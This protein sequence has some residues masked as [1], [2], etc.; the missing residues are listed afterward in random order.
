LITGASTSQAATWIWDQNQNRI[1]DRI[2]SVNT[3]GL[4]AA[5][6]HHDLA[7]KPIIHVFPG[8]T[9]TYGVYVG[10]DHHPTDAD[11][12]ALTAAGATLTWRPRYIDYLRA[13]ASFAQIQTLAS[14]GG[15]TRVEAWQVM[16]PFN[17]NATRTLRARDAEGGVG[18][19]MFPSVWKNLGYTGK[20]VVVGII[21]TGVNDAAFGPYPGHESLRGKWVGGGDFSNPDASLNTPP[22][23]SANPQNSADPLG[24]YHAT[25]V[26]GTSIGSGGPQGLLNGAAPGRYAGMAPDARLVDCKALSDAGVG[27]GAAEALEWCIAHRSTVWNANEPG[28]TYRG[29]QV[30]NMSLGG[31]SASDGTDADCAAVNAAVK[32]GIAVCVA[33][34]NDGNTA[35][36]P[37]PAAA[38]QDIAVGAFQDA[39]SLQHS[40]DIVADYSN[41][42]PRMTDGDADHYDEMKPSVMGS[43]SDIVSALGDPSSNG[44]LYHNINGTSMATPCITGICALIL[45]ANPNLTPAQLRDVLQN[46]AEH[47]TDHGKQAPSAAD[48]FHLDPNYHPSWGWGETDAY[49]AVKEALNNATTQVVAEGTSSV[50]NMGGHLQIGIRWVTQREI[51]VTRFVVHRAP[52]LGGFPGD[53]TLASPDVTP[54]GHEAIERVSNRTLYNWTDSDLSL[55]VGDT[56][57]YQVRWTDTHGFEHVEPAFAVKTDVPPVRARVQ[58]VLTHTALDNDVFARFGSGTSYLTPAYL[59]ATGGTSS[60][61]SSRVVFPVGFG[62]MTRYFFHAD[63]TDRDVVAPF[64]PPSNANPWFLAV[65]EKGYV[66]TEGF[67]DSFSVTTYDDQGQP[68]GTQ[69]ALN[70]STPTAEGQTTVFWIPADPATQLNHT[71]VL[72]P[73]GHKSGYQG[74]DLTFQVHAT[75]A[76]AQAI[77]Y[78]ASGL[79]SGAT[80]DPGTRTFD[81]TP[82]FSQSGDFTVTFKATDTM[83]A[84]DAEDVVLSIATR[85]PGS[86]T[87]PVLAPIGDRTTQAGVALSFH[88]TATDR[89]G[90]PLTYS[91]TPLPSG[92]T[93]DAPTATFSWTPGAGDVGVYSVTFKVEDS[94]SASDSQPVTIT[95]TSGGTSFPTSCNPE[96]TTFTGTIGADVQGTMN[97]F[98]LHPFSV[99]PGTIEIQGALSWTGGPAIDLD[100]YLLDPSGNVASSGATATSDPEHALYVNPDPGTYQWKVVSFDNP[101]PN[102]AYTVTSMLCMSTL[103]G[104]GGG[105]NAELAL[106]PNAPNP[107]AKSSVIRFALAR[108]GEVKLRIYDL[109]GRLIRTL[110]NG[111]MEAGWHQRVWDGR[112]DG[113]ERAV[114]GV[115][116]SRLDAPQG[117]R[118]SKMVMIK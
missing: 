115:Y 75:D 48:P 62:P 89:E 1:D 46:T 55:V 66:N 93:F 3:E 67:V 110:V 84:F 86:N 23:S 65:L 77:T 63:L 38:D 50:S 92:A 28:V 112:S 82:S 8:A 118:S 105:P 90:G 26:A 64:L 117:M 58:W 30:V 73:I 88:V 69:R 60:A 39:N 70:P 108:G 111:P 49:A 9:L 104:V 27:G 20:G 13:Q 40:D 34:G 36:M 61:D 11:V 32:A 24:D 97:V 12:S 95:V 96:T 79:P 59:H 94:G 81:W 15:V 47:R 41:E 7:A 116:F 29:V 103:L 113:G 100:L 71:P 6:L 35:Y 33:T 91:A 57:W 53:F 80:F 102:L 51:G 44:T 16:V 85:A 76:D 21:D 56:Y 101:N 78:S 14:L 68:T 45:Q 74:L 99:L 5:H 109:S 98:T 22:D 87:A 54:V 10:F 4:A 37:S 25:H 2:E 114:P 17:D 52:D 31:M 72:D 107:F 19:G 83:G 42:G 106:A 18:A 43:G